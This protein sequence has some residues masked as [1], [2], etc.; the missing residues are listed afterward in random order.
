M[1]APVENDEPP[2]A[3][4][5]VKLDHGLGAPNLHTTRRTPHAARRT[6]HTAYRKAS[7]GC[8]VGASIVSE[9]RK[10][11]VK[12]GVKRGAKMAS[13]QGWRP[14]GGTPRAAGR[15]AVMQRRLYAHVCVWWSV[16]ACTGR[17]SERGRKKGDITGDAHVG[18]AT[19]D[20][21]VGVADVFGPLRVRLPPHVCSP[22]PLRVCP[23]GRRRV[24]CHEA[25]RERIF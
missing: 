7:V 8:Q 20:Y 9:R 16:R 13:A 19:D 12:R 3:G 24:R 22:V 25:L 6:P 10:H 11:G 23:V 2:S 15:Q 14:E 21:E 5:E 4:E 1:S 18:L 17:W